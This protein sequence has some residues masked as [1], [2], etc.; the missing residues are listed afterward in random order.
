MSQP[1]RKTHSYKEGRRFY[2]SELDMYFRSNWE[3]ELVRLLSE[4][5]I[6]FK[7][8][9]QRFYFRAERESYLPDFYLPAYNTFIEVK[10]YMDMRSQKRCQLFK[11]KYGSTYG[12]FLWEK[13]ERELILKNPTLLFTFLEVAQSE[14]ERRAKSD[15]L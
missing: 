5:G 12:Y 4:L 13:E 8:E 3:I 9:P 6:S 11:K 2:C 14:Q 7:Y 10:G 1:K 15:N